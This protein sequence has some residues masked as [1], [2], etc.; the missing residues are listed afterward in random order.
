M[1]G[2]TRQPQVGALSPEGELLY[3]VSDLVLYLNYQ[4]R[5]FPYVKAR[6]L[7]ALLPL[8]P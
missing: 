5:Y 8:L 7:G 3:V 6:P 4:A 2:E 1:V